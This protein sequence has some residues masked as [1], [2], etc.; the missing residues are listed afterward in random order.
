[1]YKLIGGL[2]KQVICGVPYTAL[3][4][5][6][7]MSVTHGVAM[8]MR[9]KEAKS[10][11]TKKIIEGVFEAGDD[12]VII[13]DLITSGTSI[14]ETAQQLIDVGLKVKHAVVLLDR[15]QGGMDNL[16]QFSYQAAG[17]A[18]E[19]EKGQG[20]DCKAVLTIQSMLD[21][22]VK[23]GKLTDKSTIDRVHQ[24]LEEHRKVKAAVSLEKKIAAVAKA[25]KRISFEERAKLTSNPTSQRLLQLMARKK[26]CLCVSAD[27]RTSA[28]LVGLADA[29]GP[30][31]CMLKTHIDI[32]C[33]FD[34]ALI[35]QLRALADKHDF[36]IFEDRKFADIG[37]T[38]MSQFGGGI[39]EI[40][41][42]A[43]LV[44]AHT[45][46]GRGII[47][48]LRRVSAG[49][50]AVDGSAPPK[51]GLILLAEMSSKENLT[52]LPGYTETSIK[53]ARDNQD[54]VCGFISMRALCPDVP[55]MIC[56]TPG[57]HL[58]SKGDAVGQ[59]Y[60]V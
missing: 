37:N 33:D 41:S 26:S 54:F 38:V 58:T 24:F 59:Q 48:G 36:V 34:A 7:C 44:N 56:M 32:I 50:D 23:H 8:V 22:L 27:V 21:T 18:E 57:V 53:W 16:R 29:L 1:M 43:H 17:R 11:G 47:D 12:C 55:G 10:Y 49:A 52:S 60:K 20:I 51:H 4:I 31:I 14:M 2:P 15:Q 45:V 42:W 30:H 40:A 9:R 6:S 35:E 19:E 3:P 39:Y 25:D 13:E 5:A 46:P 28:E